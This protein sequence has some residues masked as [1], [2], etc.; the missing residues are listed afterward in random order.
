MS[1]FL[2]NIKKIFF[3]ALFAPVC[4]HCRKSVSDPENFLC[5]ECFKS[6]KIN[7]TLFCPVCRARVPENRKICHF[8]CPYLLAAACDYNDPV[9]QSAIHY[10]K[11]KRIRSLSKR[12]SEIILNCVSEL[13]FDFS[14]FTVAPIPLHRKKEF[15]RGFNQSRI[16]AEL[17]SKKLNLP[18][19]D[20]LV[21]TKN[22]KQQAGL[23]DY[24]KRKENAA[25]CFSAVN[26]EKISGKNI[27][28]VD[29]VFTSGAT[30][31]EAVKVLKSCGAKK[32]IALVAA[33]A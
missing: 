27:I 31:N 19:E 16:I 7:K 3:D 13:N 30:M 14:G 28:L 8:D 22:N 12:I 18:L 1:G 4:A 9:V 23:R 15:S 24:E 20:L 10:L 6:A 29:D 5:E 2:S 11:Y 25:G 21:K 17:I 26:P 32:I 33:K